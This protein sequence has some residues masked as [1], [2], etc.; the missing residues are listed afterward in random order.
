MKRLNIMQKQRCCGFIQ[1]ISMLIA[2]ILLAACGVPE[3][4]QRPIVSNNTNTNTS[5][6][7]G[8]VPT[9]IPQPPEAQIRSFGLI[10]TNKGWIV[11]NQRFVWSDISGA[12]QQNIPLPSGV[13][14]SQINKAAF[15]DDQH[16]WVVL[17]E[18]EVNAANPAD[19]KVLRTTDGGSHWQSA[20]LNPSSTEYIDSPSG[21]VYVDFVDATNGWINVRTQSSSA[22]S[23]GLLF[24]TR[25]GGASWAKVV[26]PSGEPIKFL[27]ANDGWTRNTPQATFYATHDG[28]TTWQPM[29]LPSLPS[30]QTATPFFTLPTFYSPTEGVLPVTLAG[31]QP[32]VLFYTTKDAGQTWTLA[33]QISAPGLEAGGETFVIVRNATNW[34]VILPNGKVYNVVGAGA[35]VQELRPNVPLVGL[36]KLRVQAGMV[37]WATRSTSNCA[38]FKAQC[39]TTTAL[40]HTTDG[41]QTWAATHVP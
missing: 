37:G 34:T 13:T 17:T 29:A 32:V 22:F 31:E 33:G 11:T 7:S 2:T 1:I 40:L 8:T 10:T 38:Q 35:H 30:A 12:N 9:T 14:P 3:T 25:D 39:S 26:S 6:T 36:S 15:V 16:G 20:G 41:G 4:S 19:F 18:R 5:P 28:G 21:D 23:N 24:R 27:N